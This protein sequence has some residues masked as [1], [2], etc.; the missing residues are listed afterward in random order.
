[1]AVCVLCDQ[2]TG[3]RA[4]PALGRR[5]CSACCGAHR[6]KTVRCIPSCTFLVA[7]E[8]HLRERRAR[9][10]VQ[11]W[12]EWQGRLSADGQED[13][14]PYVEALA[15][16]LADMLHRNDADDEHVE[17]A[18]AFLAQ[19]LSPITIVG[20]APP[21]LGRMLAETLLPLVQEGRLSAPRLRDAAQALSDWLGAY[22]STADTHR[23]VHG[24]LGLIPPQ[25]EKPPGQQGG[26]IVRP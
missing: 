23:F 13:L 1:M 18:V 7:A 22:R 14:W 9:E 21:M 25:Q 19:T 26:L 15:Q 12:T 8:R 5:I 6:R 10:L 3:D 17:S 11:A 4:C 20:A 24:L 16:L 2:R